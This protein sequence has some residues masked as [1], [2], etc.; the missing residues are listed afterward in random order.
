MS[1]V[2]RRTLCCALAAALALT[3]LPPVAASA[4]ATSARTAAVVAPSPRTAPGTTLVGAYVAKGAASVVDDATRAFES[5][6]GRKLDVQRWYARWDEDLASGPV[7]AAAGRGR[8]LMLSVL[9][10]TTAGTRITWA[11]IARGEADAQIRVQAAAV[12]RLGPAVYLALHHE[13]ELASTAYGTAAEYRAAWARY[14]Q[15]FTAEG[16]SNVLWTWVA[17]LK[18]FAAGATSAFYPGDDQVDRV[19]VDAYNWAGCA[20]GQSSTW[21]SLGYILRGFRA[22]A[23]SHGKPAVLAEW[24]SVESPADPARRA[25]WLTEAFALFAGWPELEATSYFDAAGTCD[26]RLA[27]GTPA[28]TAFASA[29]AVAGAHGRPAAWLVASVPEGVGPL[30]ES[31]D[32]S[33]STGGGSGN[34]SGVVSW[35]LDPGDG[36]AAVSGTGQPKTRVAHSYA[37]SG[38]Y[39][40]TLTVTDATGASSRDVRSVHVLAAPRFTGNTARDATGTSATLTV[41]VAS[42]AMAGS[43]TLVWGVAGRTTGSSTVPLTAVSWPQTVRVPVTGLAPGTTY[44]WTTTATTA[45]GSAV[46]TRTFSTPG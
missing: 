28:A 27:S 4:V 8:V 15:V 6:I 13:A 35:S 2:T 20:A 1:A 42:D 41:W 10:L 19:G 9:P 16:T 31:F 45:G 24:G 14:R 21:H 44:T 23:T 17:S 34:G 30:N 5:S 7:V 26:W 29:A 36:C 33:D 3:A 43:V 46:L 39:S 38:W 18:P 25:V 12:A 11:A 40:P 32:L 37:A 22:F